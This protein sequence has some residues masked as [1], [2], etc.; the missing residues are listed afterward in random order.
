MAKETPVRPDF[1][2]PFPEHIAIIM[3]GNGRWARQRG[4]RRV[5]G[6]REG[7]ASVR[8]ITTECARMGV[9]SLTLY[10]FSVENWKRPRAEVRYLM[11]LLRRFLAAERNILQENDVRL[12]GIGRLADLPADARAE[13]TRTEELTAGNRGMLLRLALSY[14]GRTELA[15]AVRAIAA[16]VCAGRLDPA[17]IGE[18]TLRR[19][20]YDPSTPDPDLLIRTAGEMRLSNFLLWQVSYSELFVSPVCWPDFRRPQLLDALRE[21][22]QR[23]RKYGG[24]ILDGPF[25]AEAPP[26]P[27]DGAARR[28]ERR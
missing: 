27:A 20:L 10:A 3:D 7:I 22:A 11:D 21:Y 17:E 18:E 5:L 23:V 2:G 12:M 25:E 13:L 28:K 16:A 1:G 19:F 6:H 9:K 4:L 8:E 24:L 26:A 15:D 14:G